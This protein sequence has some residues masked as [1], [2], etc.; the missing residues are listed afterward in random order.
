MFVPFAQWA[1]DSPDLSGFGR[2]AKN[3][4]PE[5][6]YYRPFPSLG[7]LT[8][9]LESSALGAVSLSDEEGVISTFAG[10]ST[11]LYKLIVGEFEDVS[12]L[13]GYG[14]LTDTKWEFAKFGNN[15]ITTNYLDD[16]QVFDLANSSK[17]EDLG[18]SPPRAKHIAIVGD[19][20]VLANLTESFLTPSGVVNNGLQWCG[21]NDIETWT[22]DPATQ[23]DGQILENGEGGAIQG[24]A[25][26]S[27]YGIIIQERAI[28]RMNY[29]GSPAVFSFELLEKNHGSSLPNSIIGVGRDVFY[30]SDDGFYRFNGIQS[31]PIGKDRINQYFFNDFNTLYKDK[32]SVSIDPANTLVMWAYTSNDSPTEGNPNKILIYNWVS[33]RFAL[34][35]MELEILFQALTSGY[36]L[37]ELDTISDNLDTLPFSLDSNAYKGG[38]LLSGAFNSDNQLAYFRGAAMIATIDTTEIEGAKNALTEITQITPMIEGRSPMAVTVKMGTRNNRENPIVYGSSLPEN[39]FGRVKT[40][41]N[42]RYHQIQSTIE[43]GFSKATGIEIDEIK[44]GSYR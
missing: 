38:Q 19:F 13:A 8:S 43:N 6:D 39:G 28:Q 40:R 22:P 26:N 36:T 44:Q 12:R 34:V 18:G 24:I 16:V 4:I 14:P 15:V 32:M 9:S 37:E 17:F 11:K 25:G 10:D 41:V 27:N 21:I 33:D 29:V 23:A 7:A 31:I 35:E 42:A 30:I 1:P 2:V 20:V 3:C 5:K